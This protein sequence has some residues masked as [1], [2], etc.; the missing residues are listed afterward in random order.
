MLD[1]LPVTYMYEQQ[2]IRVLYFEISINLFSI[3]FAGGTQ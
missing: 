2:L 3:I 1:N